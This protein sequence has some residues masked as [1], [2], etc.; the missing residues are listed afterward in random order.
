MMKGR[1][2]SIVV[3]LALL[4]SG[5]SFPAEA[6]D[7][8]PFYHIVKPGEYVAQIARMYGVEAEDIIEENNLWNPNLIYAGQRLLIPEY[9]AQPKPG[10]T[11]SSKCTTIYVVKRGDYLK[12]IAA[13]YHTTVACLVSLNHIPNPNI[14][15]PGQRLKVPVKCTGPTPTPSP[16]GN[17]TGQYWP[18][19][20]FSGSPK[21]TIHTDKVNYNYGSKGPGCGI[22]GTNFAG[23][24]TRTRFFDQGQY[25]F[26]AI[27]DDGV[28]VWVDGVLII[29]QWHDAAVTDYTATKQLSAGNHTLQVD[30]YQNQGT[31][32]INFYPEL[33]GGG[34]A[35]KGEYFNNINL[36]GPV[37]ATQFYNDLELD[38][39]LLAPAGGVSADY[40]SARYTGTFNFV[41]GKF[42]FTATADDGIRVF[43]DDQLILDK[44][45]VTSVKTYTVDRDVSAGNHNLRVEFFENT[46]AA[47][48]KLR[49]A[50][51]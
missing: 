18:N 47:V 42:R 41:G 9:C 29:D 51:Q 15:Y 30:Y 20:F 26:H 16:T 37:V 5:L 45:Q 8:P 49:W 1:L 6:S 33:V 34:G 39:G 28:R 25:R 22:A 4:V 2:L 36:A 11:C 12:Q 10:P 17:W 27:V 31:G 13:R 50:Q 46:G 43:L 38:F 32:Q 23:R 7:C 48:V 40:F 14:I 19:R 35:W 44:W 24:F 21:C 3:L